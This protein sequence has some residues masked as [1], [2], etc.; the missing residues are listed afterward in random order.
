MPRELVRIVSGI[1]WRRTV[2]RARQFWL[3]TEL[4]FEVDGREFSVA[5]DSIPERA[6]LIQVTE[7]HSLGI[8]ETTDED[9]SWSGTG[10]YQVRI[11]D[12][13]TGHVSALTDTVR[14]GPEP[15][16]KRPVAGGM[17]EG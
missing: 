10:R 16:E 13:D 12:D 4:Y 15:A 11:N 8:V 5:L 17:S 3:E 6:F 9:R 1:R 14:W 7:T 2:I